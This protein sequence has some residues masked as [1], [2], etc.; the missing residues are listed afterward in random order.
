MNQVQTRFGL[1]E[2]R[3]RAASASA[4]VSAVKT[5]QNIKRINNHEM[6]KQKYLHLPIYPASSPSPVCV[7]AT[8]PTLPNV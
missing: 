6:A 2:S 8:P 3:R 1:Y 4:S 5:A 7:C